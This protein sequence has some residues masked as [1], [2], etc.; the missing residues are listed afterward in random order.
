MLVIFCHQNKRK[1]TKKFR[2][3]RL[4]ETSKKKTIIEETIFTEHHSRN[5]EGAISIELAIPSTLLA[6]D[7][8]KSVSNN[9]P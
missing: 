6:I 5:T 3:V 9:R 2:D 1:N 7:S 8:L 4:V